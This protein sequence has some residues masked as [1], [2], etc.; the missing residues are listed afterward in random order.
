MYF[1]V[2]KEIFHTAAGGNVCSCC[3]AFAFI[4]EKYSSLICKYLICKTY[5]EKR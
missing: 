2:L 3:D 5:V 4:R 1:K